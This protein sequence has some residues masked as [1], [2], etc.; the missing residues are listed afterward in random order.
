MRHMFTADWAF[1]FRGALENYVR[2]TC[3]QLL[4]SWPLLQ[5]FDFEAYKLPHSY[6]LFIMHDKLTGISSG[7]AMPIPFPH[8]DYPPLPPHVQEIPLWQFYIRQTLQLAACD[9]GF[10]VPIYDSGKSNARADIDLFTP[11]EKFYWHQQFIHIFSEQKLWLESTMESASLTTVNY[12]VSGPNARVNV[13]SIDNSRNVASTENAELFLQ[14]RELLARVPDVA[15]REAMTSVVS[16]MEQ[17]AG[18]PTFTQHYKCFISLAADHVGLFS[19]LLP[20]LTQ[21][22]GT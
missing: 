21:L 20:A 11:Q 13:G 18:K 15:K 14:L 17:S 16:E 6:V 10:L 7:P 22:L 19:A 9:V 5:S 3:P 1:G 8:A 2:Q 4:K 12:N